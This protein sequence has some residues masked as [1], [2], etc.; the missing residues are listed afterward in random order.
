[1]GDDRWKVELQ[2]KSMDTYG[3]SMDKLG[4]SF[5]YPW[6]YPKISK[7]YPLDIQKDTH[8]S[9]DHRRSWDISRY[10][11]VSMDIFLGRTPRWLTYIH[12]HTIHA[13][14]DICIFGYT[15]ALY[16]CMHIKFSNT[17][18]ITWHFQYIHI[19]TGRITDVVAM[20][21]SLPFE[22]SSMNG[23][24]C[25]LRTFTIRTWTD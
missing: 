18:N 7:R 12:I 6:R 19:C 15:Y 23:S 21:P 3:S 9:R 16:V 20:S 1:M 11:R 24:S 14:T 22:F 10:L 17:C 13:H 25:W 4:I 2:D 8:T 5:I